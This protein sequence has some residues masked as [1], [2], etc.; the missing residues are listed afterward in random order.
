MSYG[1]AIVFYWEWVGVNVY[2]ILLNSPWGNPMAKYGYPVGS[3]ILEREPFRGIGSD[4]SAYHGPR[5]MN[6]F[7]FIFARIDKLNGLMLSGLLKNLSKV[8]KVD[9]LV[10]L[11]SLESISDINKFS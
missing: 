1:T 4:L 10:F 2:M 5:K 3:R 8:R 6:P 7:L 9:S 11:F